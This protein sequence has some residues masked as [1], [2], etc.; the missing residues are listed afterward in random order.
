MRGRFLQQP[1]SAAHLAHECVIS[2]MEMPPSDSACEPLLPPVP[3]VPIALPPQVMDRD[4]EAAPVAVHLP[5]TTASAH[6]RRGESQLFMNIEPI[7][8]GRFRDGCCDCCAHGCC[9]GHY[10]TACCCPV[11]K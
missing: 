11:C 3:K 9:H 5:D 10:L 2:A 8:V 6:I 4:I 7:P 1:E